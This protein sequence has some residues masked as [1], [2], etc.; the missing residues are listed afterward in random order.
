MGTEGHNIVYGAGKALNLPK[1]S[2]EVL[3]SRLRE[4]T[5]S[6]LVQV[7]HFI[8]TGKRNQESIFILMA[9]LFTVQMLRGFFLLWV[10]L[11]IVQMSGD[12]LL[13]ARK[14]ALSVSCS[15][16]GTNVDPSLKDTLSL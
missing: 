8:V 2:A 7:F 9:S 13:I 14:E 15:I 1:Q 4:N 10:C 5:F 6:K 16:M 11:H 12:Y 3:A